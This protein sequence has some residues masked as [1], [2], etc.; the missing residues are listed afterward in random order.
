MYSFSKFLKI[1][2]LASLEMMGILSSTFPHSF[3]VENDYKEN[4]TPGQKVKMILN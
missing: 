3:D 2:F 4:L 1:D